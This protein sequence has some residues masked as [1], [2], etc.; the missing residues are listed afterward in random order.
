[1]KRKPI[2]KPIKTNP[3]IQKRIMELYNLGKLDKQYKYGYRT[4]ANII[5]NEFGIKISH[6][7]ICNFINHKYFKEKEKAIDKLRIRVFERD[8]YRCQMC[9][10]NLKNHMPICHHLDPTIDDV[11]DLDNLVTLC[12]R[13]HLKLHFELTHHHNW[14]YY[15]EEWRKRNNV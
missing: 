8:N 15:K 14:N 6:M 3:K 7:A 10:K 2:R 13:C 12:N 4:I 5:E 1:M 11:N 9:G